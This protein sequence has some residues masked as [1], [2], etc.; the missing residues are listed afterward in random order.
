MSKLLPLIGGLGWLPSPSAAADIRLG[1]RE[2]RL[3]SSPGSFIRAMIKPLRLPSAARNTTH[4]IRS[5][6]KQ[7][8]HFSASESRLTPAPR[9]CVS[10]CTSASAPDR[11][12]ELI[13]SA[14][15]LLRPNFRLRPLLHSHCIHVWPIVS[16]QVCSGGNIMGCLCVCICKCTSSCA[17]VTSVTYLAY[18]AQLQEYCL[19]VFSSL[20]KLLS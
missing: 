20:W 8:S 15:R 19:L 18:D 6:F 11:Q 16:L 13:A 14:R 7:S 9:V 12:E 1:C 17:S 4:F 10:V 2:T 5:V 3:S